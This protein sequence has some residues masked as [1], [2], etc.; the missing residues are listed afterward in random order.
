MQ[1]NHLMESTVRNLEQSVNLIEE[2]I[3]SIIEPTIRNND[4]GKGIIID[5]LDGHNYNYLNLE[6]GQL[7]LEIKPIPIIY[8]REN[9]SYI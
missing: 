3:K 7:E 4:K 2:R 8:N 6:L 1:K 5:D 9:I